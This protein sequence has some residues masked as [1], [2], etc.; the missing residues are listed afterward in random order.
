[1]T[2]PNLLRLGRSCAKWRAGRLL[3]ATLFLLVVGG[4]F[5]EPGNAAWGARPLN[6][7]TFAP[8]QVTTLRVVAITDTSLVL[9]WTEVTSST[10]AINRYA[11]R[12]SRPPLNW[13]TQADV[14]TGNCGAP[15]YGSTAAG[16]RT[17]ACVLTGLQSN[18]AYDV[19]VI[20]YTGVLNSTAVFGPVSNVVTATTAERIGS[21]MVVRPRM[22][23]DTIGPLRS[24]DIGSV[25]T[26]RWPVN[27]GFFSGSYPV[28][29][30]DVLD[31]VRAYG[32]LLIV[33]P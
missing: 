17:R 23:I 27:M 9:T 30:R 31:S 16:G 22:Y 14:T 8:G 12:Y 13:P 4:F 19:Q 1:M 21:L 33:K 32:Y 28:V 11:V 15:V 10:S 5:A 29:F 24:V 18:T 3:V 25:G 26:W 7:P 2:H 20:A 6:R